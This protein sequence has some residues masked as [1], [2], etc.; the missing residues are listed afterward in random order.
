MG[1]AGFL[2]TS[3][4]FDVMNGHCGPKEIKIFLFTSSLEFLSFYFN[5]CIAGIHESENCCFSLR[6]ER[7]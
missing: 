2:M 3:T 1:N 5:F 6:S 4:M 7:V